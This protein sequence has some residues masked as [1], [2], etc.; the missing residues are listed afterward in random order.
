MLEDLQLLERAMSQM[1][2][3][4]ARFGS[5]SRLIKTGIVSTARN[6][7]LVSK[8]KGVVVD[9]KLL[10]LADQAASDLFQDKVPFTLVMCAWYFDHIRGNM[11]EADRYWKRAC[12]LSTGDLFHSWYSAFLLEHRGVDAAIAIYDT[13]KSRS[14][15]G[16][17][18]EAW[19]LAMTDGRHE[20]AEVIWSAFQDQDSEERWSAMIVPFLLGDVEAVRE[21]ADDWTTGFDWA[22]PHRDYLID[23]GPAVE[24][25][26][27]DWPRNRLIVGFKHLRN[28]RREKA[29]QAFESITDVRLQMPRPEA[30]DSL[31]A[32]GILKQMKDNA[33]W[34]Q[35]RPLVGDKTNN[36]D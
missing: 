22:F 13:A 17:S 32:A 29:M 7:A 11:D 25:E 20:E 30:M 9:K 1:L 21:T 12:E 28:G 31:Y 18:K 15:H 24:Y 6:I 16:K 27:S 35:L 33:G 26:G 10:A 36:Q 4:E 34:P 19:L 23:R 5:D 3:V 2:T 8:S 14:I